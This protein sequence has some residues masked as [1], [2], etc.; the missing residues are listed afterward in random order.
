[1]NDYQICHVTVNHKRKPSALIIED[2]EGRIYEIKGEAT[3]LTGCI[4]YTSL[5][6]VNRLRRA[7][8]RHVQSQWVATFG[9]T[10]DIVDPE[11]QGEFRTEVVIDYLREAVTK[12][13]ERYDYITWALRRQQYHLTQRICRHAHD[14]W[15]DIFGT[16]TDA[17]KFDEP[18][19]GLMQKLLMNS[20]MWQPAGVTSP[21]EKAWQ[22]VVTDLG[23]PIE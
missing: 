20:V 23:Y 10:K 8:M 19:L 9:I 15:F 7:V 3:Q 2:D 1:M 18:I 4:E 21:Q 6:D 17:F 14:K 16:E 12:R 22:K 5:E 13:P 11:P